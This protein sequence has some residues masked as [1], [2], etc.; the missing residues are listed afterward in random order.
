MSVCEQGCIMVPLQYIGPI[1][2]V[3]VVNCTFSKKMSVRN[4]RDRRKFILEENEESYGKSQR[5][6]IQCVGL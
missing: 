2:S 6:R 1:L 5:Y 4:C 3:T